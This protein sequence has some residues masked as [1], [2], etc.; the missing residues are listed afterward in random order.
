MSNKSDKPLENKHN[1]TLLI[2]S[3][4][5]AF[6]IWI[7]VFNASDSVITATKSVKLTVINENAMTDR[8]LDYR[9]KTDTVDVSYRVRS[10]DI[11]RV[12][13]GDF[14]AYVDLSQVSTSGATEVYVD[15][16]N[17][18]SSYITGIEAKPSVISV[19]TEEIQEVQLP[20]EV[21]YTGEPRLNYS[22]SSTTLSNETVTVKG[23]ASH[24]GRI[25][26]AVATVD[27]D[28]IDTDKTG[29]STIRFYDSNNNRVNFNTDN[30]LE[31]NISSVSYSL[32]VA[33]TKE[34]ELYATVTG[35]P[36]E[37]MI[38][39]SYKITPSTVKIIG[40]PDIINSIENISLGTFDVTGKTAAYTEEVDINTRLPEGAMLASL[41]SRIK[42]DI[43][44]A[45]IEI[46]VSTTNEA[47]GNREDAS[48]IVETT[49]SEEIGP[50]TIDNTVVGTESNSLAVTKTSS[51]TE[52]SSNSTN[53]SLS[54]TEE[55][56]EHQSDSTHNRSEPESTS[57][58]N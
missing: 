6:V 56:S 36:A 51:S 45:E 39:T 27:I 2:G 22:L 57:E 48:A 42:V 30:R 26:K 18:K 44:I 43:N 19:S 31:S 17:N 11:G 25:S 5:I 40:K 3:L 24:L 53:E 32:T 58:S 13:S 50:G 38:Y 16:L 49:T 12:G 29:E 9:L 23:P 47:E 34:I 15:I 33:E 20:V 10:Q 28:K 4:I 41:V 21:E 8:N 1:I 14:N 52:E 35:K 7:V 55:S 46:P 37:G 54:S